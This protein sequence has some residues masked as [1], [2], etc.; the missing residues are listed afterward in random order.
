M[1]A[2][3]VDLNDPLNWYS[4][5]LATSIMSV[6]TQKLAGDWRIG[7]S[8]NEV[9]GRWLQNERAVPLTDG[10]HC[11]IAAASAR[12]AACGHRALGVAYRGLNALPER[13]ELERGLVF[14]GLIGLADPPRADAETAVPRCQAAGIR[15]VMITGDHP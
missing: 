15:P 13:A 3:E 4:L 11:E 10:A 12:L 9:C 1:S 2:N 6:W 5:I 14:V 8:L 7:M